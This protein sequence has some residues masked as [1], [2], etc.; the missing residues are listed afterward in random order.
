MLYG[1]M[2]MFKPEV[3]CIKLKYSTEKWRAVQCST[4]QYR[5][6]DCA[7][8]YSTVQYSTVQC[9]TVQCCTLPQYSISLFKP[10]VILC[11]VKGK[12][13]G[14]WGTGVHAMYCQRCSVQFPVCTAQGFI[15]AFKGRSLKTLFTWIL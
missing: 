6:V 8:Q 4:V 7:L 13:N 9:N 2:S 11:A 14:G 1:P 15:C 10:E 12:P 5:K 3:Q